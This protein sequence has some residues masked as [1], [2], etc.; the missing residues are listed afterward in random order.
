MENK[1]IDVLLT[2]ELNTN[3]DHAS[4]KYKINATLQRHLAV[5]YIAS[6]THYPTETEH[7]PGGTVIWIN[8]LLSKHMCVKIQDPLGR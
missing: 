6:Q 8:P 5:H 2:Q 4:A 3:M 7:K 1:E